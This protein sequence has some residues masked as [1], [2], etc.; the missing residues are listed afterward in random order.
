MVFLLFVCGVFICCALVLAYDN[1]LQVEG[2]GEVHF[3]GRLLFCM[4]EL[5]GCI[6]QRRTMMGAGAGRG[7]VQLCRAG[8]R[9]RSREHFPLLYLA[10]AAQFFV[11]TTI[12]PPTPRIRSFK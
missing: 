9:G 3:L 11:A 2:G 4:F 7:L 5:I 8:R 12:P 1:D 10:G 6:V